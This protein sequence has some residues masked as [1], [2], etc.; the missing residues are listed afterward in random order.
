MPGTRPD[1]TK[2]VKQVSQGEQIHRIPKTTR[3]TWSPTARLLIDINDSNFPYRQD[4]IR[5]QQQL[6]A[7]RGAE[8]LE[9]H[10][11]YDEP[12]GTIA[13]YESG[14][15]KSWNRGARLLRTRPY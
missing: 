7:W 6:I 12:G 13:R 1:L 5:L 4:F 8:G 2:L 15:E 3:Y 14:H 11:I 10:Y 9:I